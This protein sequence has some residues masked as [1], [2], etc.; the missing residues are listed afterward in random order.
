[1]SL[2]NVLA[3]AGTDR[4]LVLLG[5]PQQLAQPAKGVHPEG[6]GVS[7]L[8]HVLGH[9]PT[10]APDHGVFLDRTWRMHP[11]VCGFVSSVMYEC[12]LQSYDSCA[13]QRVASGRF[14]GAGLR[15]VPVEHH[16]N[17]SASSEEAE[18][19]RGLVADVVGSTWTDAGGVS[20]RLTLADVLIIAPYNA[21]VARLRSRL[22]DGARIGTVDKFQG[23]EAPVVIY[24]MATSSAVDAPRDLEFLYSLNRLNVAVS[25]A[26]GLA[27]IVASPRLLDAPVRTPHQL[28]LVNAL[29]RYV[30]VAGTAGE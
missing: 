4:N 2:A 12:R 6:A 25:R 3:V 14:L 7:A 16:G 27:M 23:Q 30:E 17:A 24:S 9:A 15:W 1:M 26:R 19:V 21:Q 22:P 20:R 10:I 28:R 5:D 29:C 8:D 11:A 18:V 13:R